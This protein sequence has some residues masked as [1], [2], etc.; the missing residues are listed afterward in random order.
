MRARPRTVLA[1]RNTALR[2]ALFSD[3]LRTRLLDVA[4][5]DLDTVVSDFSGDPLDLTTVEVLLTGWGCPRIDRDVLALMPQLALV[6]H[7]GGTV[8]GHVDRVCWDRG[9]TVTTAAAVNAVPVAEFALAQILLAN[10]AVLRATHRYAERRA[11]PERED[12][13]VVGNYAR[14]VGIIGASTIGRLL[15]E[16]LRGFDLDVV[17]SDPTIDEAEADRLG[18]RWVTLEELMAVSDVVSLH[19]PVL[20][21]A[22]GMIGAAQLAQ[23]K[24]HATFINTARGVLVDHAALRRELASGRIT[25]LLDVT[26]PEPLPADDPLFSMPN[27]QLTPHIAGSMGTE[28]YRLTA[29]AVEEI[30]RFAHDRP[31]RFPVT[32]DDLDQM[33]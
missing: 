24:D 32:R 2:D 26:D 19:A 20:P 4:D 7:A 10:K 14:T 25:A 9:V 30:D 29:S 33:A 21:S 22:I 28:L 27:V 3:S 18:A 11:R 31:A 5:C 6:A 23:M 12:L 16:R 15:L 17:L 1:M 8:K 13:P